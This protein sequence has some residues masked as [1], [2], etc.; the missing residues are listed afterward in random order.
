MN[1]LDILLTI[2]MVAG[3]LFGLK[4][5]L[6]GAAFSAAGVIVGWQ[7]AG[8]FADDLG[9]AMSG[10][11][12]SDTVATFI[13]YALIIAATSTVFAVALMLLR[14]AL[15]AATQGLSD[16]A[17]KL[18]G[19]ALGAVLAM[20]VCGAVITGLT[21]LAYDFN[22]PLGGHAGPGT[23]H[24]SG[25]REGL[26]GALVDSSF[27]RTFVA[28]VY[29]VPGD[30]LGFVPDDFEVAASILKVRIDAGRY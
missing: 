13:W 5:G 8:H 19:L 4:M 10:S 9:A 27:A 2:L 14:P 22:T 24:A 30:A 18:G 23:V 20:L 6:I 3:L 25:T 12:A 11:A 21:R 7:I 16:A 15:T 29:N 17:D 26:S 1:W 28:V